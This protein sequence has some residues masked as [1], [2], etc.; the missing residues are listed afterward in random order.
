M[1][2]SSV[3]IEA[4]CTACGLCEQICPDVFEVADTAKV[5]S[6]ADLAET[7]ELVREAAESCPV[8]CI[9]VS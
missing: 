6:G 5:R 4:G 9:I 2:I 1:T 3:S 8:S 7:E